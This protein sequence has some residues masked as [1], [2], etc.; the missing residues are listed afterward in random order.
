MLN[1]EQVP[2]AV[3]ELRP[4]LTEC[5]EISLADW[6]DNPNSGA[7]V[8]FRLPDE[9]HLEIYRGKNRAGRTQKF[10]QRYT[11][12][13]IE[14]DDDETPVNHERRMQMEN[15]DKKPM[16]LPQLAGYLCTLPDFHKWIVETTG[17][18]CPD[19]EAAA[20]FVRSLCGIL[21]RRDLG[22]NEAAAE[23]FRTL[24]HDFDVWKTAQVVGEPHN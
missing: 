5:C 6:Q 9:T 3:D 24:A 4:Y 20:A 23:I 21:S 14:I 16:E 13:L 18:P 1:P 2:G 19:K 10:G 11:M 22:T 17:E 8:K 12:M 7:W 15:P